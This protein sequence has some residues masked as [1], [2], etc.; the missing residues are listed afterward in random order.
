MIFAVRMHFQPGETHCF[1]D[2]DPAISSSHLPLNSLWNH[3]MQKPLLQIFAHLLLAFSLS[4]QPENWEVV[5]EKT[6]AK[7]W[8]I[9]G[10]VSG[11]M[12]IAALDLTSG[13]RF[14]VNENMVFP[15]GSAIKIPVLMEVYKQATEGK[16]RLMDL[17]WIDKQHKVGGSGILQ[18]LGDHTSQLSIR[19]LA[20]LMIVLSD[21]TATNMLIDLVGMENVNR[22]MSSLGLTQTR[23]QRRMINAAASGK[24]EENLS[25]PSEAVRIMEVLHRGEFLNRQVCDEILEILKKPKSGG[26]NAGL[27]ANLPVAFKPGGIPGVSTEWA[28]VYLKE[29]PYAVA[30]MENYEMNGE[31]KSAM[32][33]ISRT[34]YDYFWRLGNATRYGTYVEPALI[35]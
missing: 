23:L 32:K 10:N 1:G 17:R 30:V 24:G 3:A 5:H 31:A 28:I 19:D 18:Q 2:N 7:L 13:E 15:Q 20:I 22:T 35:K 27:P 29:R 26:L 16:F 4:A 21:N 33:E 34:L 6:E 14:G 9:A 11:V 8:E 25:T 12:G